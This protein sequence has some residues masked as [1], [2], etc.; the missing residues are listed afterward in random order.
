MNVKRTD[1]KVT[2]ARLMIDQGRTRT[3]IAKTLGIAPKTLRDWLAEPVPDPV[4][5]PEVTIPVDE[6]IRQAQE[7]APDDVSDE[8]ILDELIRDTTRRQ[9]VAETEAGRTVL[10]RL[11]MQ[12]V[13]H[14][15]KMRPAPPPDPN[16][17]PL[18]RVSAEKCITKLHELLDRV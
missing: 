18:V 8:G 16:A 9:R 11:L 17:N 13:D 3:E 1:D 14:R 12:L 5:K 7:A 4:P 15:F 10:A 2:A 6:I